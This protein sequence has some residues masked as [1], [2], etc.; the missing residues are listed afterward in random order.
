MRRQGLQACRSL[1]TDREGGR[2]GRLNRRNGTGGFSGQEQLA[3]GKT[4]GGILMRAIRMMGSGSAE[5][6]P[7]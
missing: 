6:T 7:G 2:N 3:R 5:G 4:D 1:R